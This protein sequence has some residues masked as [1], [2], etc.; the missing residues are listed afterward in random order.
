MLPSWP[1]ALWCWK[2][3]AG[4]KLAKKQVEQTLREGRTG[5]IEG[6][7]SKAGKPFAPALTLEGEGEVRLR[8]WATTSRGTRQRQ[9]AGSGRGKIEERPVPA[10]ARSAPKELTC[11]MCGQRRIIEGRRGF[12]CNHS[13]FTAAYV[14]RNGCAFQ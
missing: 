9:G 3:V 14:F 4:R 10:E 5:R 13:L 12:G 8:G 11:P 7:T 1:R 2:R 6:F